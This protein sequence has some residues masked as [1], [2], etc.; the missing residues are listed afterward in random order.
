MNVEKRS[1]NKEIL[2]CAFKFNQFKLL[3][4]INVI[5]ISFEVVEKA[6]FSLRNFIERD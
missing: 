3:M 4:S 2:T 1:F 6:I 5:T